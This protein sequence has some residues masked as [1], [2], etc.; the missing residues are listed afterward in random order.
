MSHEVNFSQIDRA[1]SSGHVSFIQR[2][3]VTAFNVITSQGTQVRSVTGSIKGHR[4]RGTS[5]VKFEFTRKV[6]STTELKFD[7]QA[8]VTDLAGD[9]LLY[10]YVG[11]GEIIQPL[12]DTV[13]AVGGPLFGTYEI[14][15]AS[16]MFAKLIA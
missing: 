11:T 1:D 14:T 8:I 16:R 3:K 4:I 5:I 15:N 2:D 13:F 9:Q 12:D 7:N 6:D 10:R